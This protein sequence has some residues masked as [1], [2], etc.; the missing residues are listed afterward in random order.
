MV[1]GN[2]RIIDKEELSVQRTALRLLGQCFVRADA[3]RI[4]GLFLRRH[5]IFRQIP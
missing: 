5:N 1:I 4:Q 2:L 3:D